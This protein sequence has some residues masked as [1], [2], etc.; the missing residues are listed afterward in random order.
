MGSEIKIHEV[1]SSVMVLVDVV[2]LVQRIL[3]NF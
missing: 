3:Q 2:T 1:Q